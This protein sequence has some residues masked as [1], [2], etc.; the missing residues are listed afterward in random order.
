MRNGLIRQWC[1]VM[2][3]LVGIFG[4]A[5][6]PLFGLLIPIGIIGCFINAVVVGINLAGKV[7]SALDKL[8]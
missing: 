8:K 6:S 5:A 1:F 7:D 4:L 2:L 3:I